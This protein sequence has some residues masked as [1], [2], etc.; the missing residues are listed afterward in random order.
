MNRARFAVAATLV[1]ASFV[2]APVLGARLRRRPAPQMKSVLA[3]KKFTPP[4]RGEARL[5]S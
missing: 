4:V 3:G 1:G 2:G 5:T